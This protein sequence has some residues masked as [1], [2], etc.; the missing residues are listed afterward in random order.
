MILHNPFFMVNFENEFTHFREELSNI[1]IKNF[2]FKIDK[3]LELMKEANYD[4]TQLKTFN[5]DNFYYDQ[6]DLVK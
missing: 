3:S 6:F 5:F 1:I 2:Y 4:I